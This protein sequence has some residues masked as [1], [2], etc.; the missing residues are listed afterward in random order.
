MLDLTDLFVILRIAALGFIVTILSSLLKKQGKETE[1]T[2]LSLIGAIVVIIWLVQYILQ[3][4]EALQTMFM[5]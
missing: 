4:F 1:A 5:F 3:M 2:A